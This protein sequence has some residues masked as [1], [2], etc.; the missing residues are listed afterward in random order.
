[1][2]DRNDFINKM[3]VYDSANF[4]ADEFATLSYLASMNPDIVKVDVPDYFKNEQNAKQMYLRAHAKEW[5]TTGKYGSPGPF[6]SKTFD[7]IINPAKKSV[8]D[9]IAKFNEEEFEYQQEEAEEELVERYKPLADILSYGI[10]ECIRNIKGL[11]SIQTGPEGK[12][13]FYATI[14]KKAT[15]IMEGAGNE[16]L[17]E[18]VMNSLTDEMKTDIKAVFKL[19]ELQDKKK[20]AQDR[21]RE[22]FKAANR[23]FSDAEKQSCYYDI[24]NFDDYAEDWY[25]EHQNYIN[26]AQYKNQDKLI[27]DKINNAKKAN[28]T[29]LVPVYENAKEELKKDRPLLPEGAKTNLLNDEYM[30]ALRDSSIHKID[31]LKHCVQFLKDQVREFNTAQAVA[32]MNE[33]KSRFVIPIDRLKD[34]YEATANAN[35]RFE[36]ARNLILPYLSDEMLKNVDSRL[37]SRVKEPQ[38]KIKTTNNFASLNTNSAPQEEMNIFIEE[39]FAELSKDIYRTGELTRKFMDIKLPGYVME[40]GHPEKLVEKTKENE[41]KALKQNLENRLNALQAPP[42]MNNA[43][44]NAN[45]N[46]AQPNANANNAQPNANANNALQIQKLQ[47]N[48]ALLDEVNKNL[49][50]VKKRVET[51]YTQKINTTT[52]SACELD[53]ATHSKNELGNGAYNDMILAKNPYRYVG[54]NGKSSDD[55]N[56]I[57]QDKANALLRLRTNPVVASDET[58]RKILQIANIMNGL[59][60]LAPDG[61]VPMEEEGKIYGYKKL[62]EA[63]TKLEE[64]VDGGNMDEIRTAN[65]TYKQE[66]KK[67]S[68]LHVFI[69][70]LFPNP[71]VVPPNIDSGRNHLIPV[72]FTSDVYT[73]SI[74]NSIYLLANQCRKTGVK[75]EDYLKNPVTAT[76]KSVENMIGKNGFD[77]KCA[78]FKNVSEAFNHYADMADT[79]VV[80]KEIFSDYRTFYGV[81]RPLESLYHLEAN[82]ELRNDLTRQS[83]LVNDLAEMRGEQEVTAAGVISKFIKDGDSM[84]EEANRRFREGIKTALISGGKLEKKYLPIIDTYENGVE[85]PDTVNY[86]EALAV[87]NGYRSLI[88][89]YKANESDAL[90]N[91]Y[92]GKLLEESLFDYLK[93]H[94]EDMEKQEYKELEKVALD[95]GFYLD[96]KTTQASEYQTFKNQYNQK[97]TELANAVKTDETA[98]NKDIV[99]IQKDLKKAL[100]D[101]RSLNN[102]RMDTVKIDAE[103]K[104]LENKLANAI[105]KRLIILNNEYALGKVTP[106]YLKTRH[107]QLKALKQNPANTDYLKIPEFVSKKA[108]ETAADA[109]IIRK[110]V[111]GKLFSGHMKNLETFKEWKM[112]EEAPEW[113]FMGNEKPRIEYENQ[114]SAEAWQKEYEKEIIKTAQITMPA[115]TTKTAVIARNVQKRNEEFEKS[116]LNEKTIL[117]SRVADRGNVPTVTMED[118]AQ[119]L[120]YRKTEMRN[121]FDGGQAA[122]QFIPM[123]NEHQLPENINMNQLDHADG[124][125]FTVN[126]PMSERFYHDVAEIIALGI[127]ENRGGKLPEGN[128]EVFASQIMR[129]LSFRKIMLPLSDK[130]AEELNRDYQPGEPRQTYW[131]DRLMQM[132]DD[133]TIVKAYVKQ[134]EAV[135][136]NDM[137]ADGIFMMQDAVNVAEAERH[138]AVNPNPF[139]VPQNQVG[140]QQNQVGGPNGPQQGVNHQ[141][142]HQPQGNGMGAM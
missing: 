85:K 48:I 111:T 5:T 92:M 81:T 95:A 101:Q 76:E 109:T 64:A 41:I 126:D 110:N 21:L 51:Y 84:G 56:Y 60:L 75:V 88:T 137:A 18:A 58:N 13:S 104:K 113:D 107:Q 3:K 106:S 9:A 38:L 52:F 29:W 44:P 25:R 27:T 43:Q 66:Y 22:D 96:V 37:K 127:A 47:Q 121:K 99:K 69:K 50:K 138:A 112:H 71:T 54:G 122:T 118:A 115:G 45:A 78:S 102:S 140:V 87:P 40:E 89:M 11:D 134:K 93:A 2:Y 130:L 83:L 31:E 28:Q 12:F 61:N 10:K 34:K 65:E 116:I 15:G 49:T 36:E 105:D 139:V 68:D 33:N 98:F 114:L 7:N 125:L 94:P 6:T 108:E 8:A 4:S 124:E 24:A 23:I 73:D 20:T 86:E 63:K 79:D 16:E 123:E 35:Y 72:E 117:A 128:L 70:E 80:Y 90:Q 30:A 103:V 135:K 19:K 55:I 77:A 74:M 100:K 42:A 133:R 82:K 67:I 119:T 32:E 26:T 129:D 91:S 53:E 57:N 141:P 1:M 132:L 46:N 17:K 14:L 97:A 131:A 62:I 136:T 142:A 39:L 120:A 59:E